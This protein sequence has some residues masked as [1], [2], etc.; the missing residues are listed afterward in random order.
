MVKNRAEKQ[1]ARAIKAKSGLTYPRAQARLRAGHELQ[2]PALFLGYGS[3]GEKVVHRPGRGKILVAGGGTG[4][5]K[6]LLLSRLAAEASGTAPVYV[7]DAAKYGSDYRAI[8]GKLAALETT[9][10][11]AL[12][13]VKSL[14]EPEHSASLLVID[15]IAYA[16]DIPGFREALWALSDSGMSIIIGGQV[17][18]RS[19]PA[20]LMARA[21]RMILGDTTYGDRLAMFRNPDAQ[22]LG[23]RHKAILETTTGTV[24]VILPPGGI[25]PKPGYRF[26]FGT[27]AAGAPAVFNPARDG[28]LVVT[29]CPGAGKSWLLRALAAD[30][31]KS[32]DVYI[33]STS[34]HPEDEIRTPW[35]AMTAASLEAT[36]D[37]LQEIMREINVRNA[38]CHRES[39]SRA[40]DLREAPRP[41]L[42]VLDEFHSLVHNDPMATAAECTPEDRN[43]RARVAVAVGK[44]A[45]EGRSAGV[46]LV[47]AGYNADLQLIPG[48]GD[49]MSGLSRLVLGPLDGGFQNLTAGLH[50]PALRALRPAGRQ[51]VYAPLSGVGGLV[52]IVLP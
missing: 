45:R 5:G 26:E 52:D 39:V 46:S 17:P 32:M 31:V 41:I 3:D 47:V 44:L 25:V 13:C 10:A 8:R 29:G 20:A 34:P 7:I 24:Q 15:E 11:G 30:A 33:S 9:A 42:V 43:S 51:G 22:V 18:H 50:D 14:A 27:D 21:D 6:S 4:T 35:A 28:H 40:S 36:A 1:N 48:A 2:F 12:A 38:R 16:D 49:L 23:G 37:M 19:L